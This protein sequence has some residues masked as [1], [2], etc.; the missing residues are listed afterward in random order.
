M[1][2]EGVKGLMST[3]RPSET[4]LKQNSTTASMIGVDLADFVWFH[5]L[6]VAARLVDSPYSPY[7][8][9][10]GRSRWAERRRCGRDG[11]RAV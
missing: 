9:R 2:T 4:S 10:C 8:G 1:A 7:S 6:E 3:I 11:I 5:S